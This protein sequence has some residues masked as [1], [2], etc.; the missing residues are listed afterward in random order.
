[1]ANAA[2]GRTVTARPA[3]TAPVLTPERRDAALALLAAIEKHQREHGTVYVRRTATSARTTSGRPKP[4]TARRRKPTSRATSQATSNP[5]RRRA[6]PAKRP[7]RTL[8]ARQFLTR[9]RQ[10]LWRKARRS[11]A[12]TAIAVALATLGLLSARQVEQ[13][14]YAPQEQALSAQYAHADDVLAD[15]ADLIRDLLHQPGGTTPAVNRAI[16]QLIRGTWAPGAAVTADGDEAFAVLTA[17]DPSLAT[18]PIN[19]DAVQTAAFAGAWMF[20]HERDRLIDLLH[21]YETDRASGLLGRISPALLGG[22]TGHLQIHLGPWTLHGEEAMNRIR[23]L[24]A[25]WQPPP[26]TPV[27]GAAP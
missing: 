10:R 26:G 18:A 2:S 15:Y 4:R 6:R 20:R 25:P 27:P 12:I 13:H 23:S 14:A 17:A 16:S 11:V 9:T 5:A 7:P 22:P 21:R 1:M 3:T 8:A 19:Y 24:V